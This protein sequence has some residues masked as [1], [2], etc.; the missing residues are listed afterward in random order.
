[1]KNIISLVLILLL[2]FTLAVGMV[3]C[4]DEPEEPIE[5]EKNPT[6][7]PE[8]EIPGWEDLIPEEGIGFPP[9]N[10]QGE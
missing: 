9:V 10:I 5:I 6:P 1:M 8:E 3:S 2:V 7:N 4:G